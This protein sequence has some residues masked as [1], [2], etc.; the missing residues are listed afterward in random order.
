MSSPRVGIARVPFERQPAPGSRTSFAPR[1]TPLPRGRTPTKRRGAPLRRVP[2]APRSGKQRDREA[3]RRPVRAAYMAAHPLCEFGACL[4]R[5]T[6]C[7]EPWTRA[8]G[9]PTDDLRNMAAL[10][11]WHHDRITFNPKEATELG[12]LVPAWDGPRWL[13]AGGRQAA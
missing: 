8:R 5:S 4:S 13:E 11:H 3:R 6:E 10:C 9:G 1:A 12:W 7:H 2:I